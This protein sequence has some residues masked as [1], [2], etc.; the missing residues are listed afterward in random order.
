[1]KKLAILFL[2]SMFVVAMYLPVSAADWNL[3]GS[4]RVNTFWTDTSEELTGLD[5]S[6]LELD[7]DLQGNAR[8]GAMVSAGELGG[9]FEYGTA[10]TGG[11][12]EA[13]VRIL[14][15]TVNLGGG[16][17]LVGKFYSPWSF[18]G[19]GVSTQVTTLGADDANMLH[20][21]A[22][23][24]RNPMLQ[25]SMNNFKVALVTPDEIVPGEIVLPR[26]EAYL[27]VPMGGMSAGIAGIY[28]A[29][30]LDSATESGGGDTLNAYGL[31]AK[32]SFKQMDPLYFNLGGFY[33]VNPTNFSEYLLVNG[34]A[35]TSNVDDVENTNV[36]G[37]TAVVGTSLGN[38][39]GVQAG[40]GL[41]SADNDNWA[42]EDEAMVYYGQAM[43][44]LGGGGKAFVVPEIGFVDLDDDG[45]VAY[46]GMKT[47]IDF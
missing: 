17:L 16:Q 20:S 47:Q 24:G 37:V 21:V 10:G 25:Y 31:A 22:Y 1:M 19:L 33:A 45:D 18:A 26:V 9:R 7:H 15:G 41:T 39:I 23:N 2:A 44:P 3:Y 32:F 13:N 11:A 4:A 35:D 27:D 46:A 12:D 14:Y 30:D 40:A 42:E 8:I 34:L 29:Y 36:Y 43:I 5:D 38:G 6:L 28:Q